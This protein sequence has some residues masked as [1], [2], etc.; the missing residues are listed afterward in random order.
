MQQPLIWLVEDEARHQLPALAILD[1]GLPDISG[2]S[3]AASCWRDKP[4]QLT[5]NKFLL[6]KKK[7]R[8]MRRFYVFCWIIPAN[9]RRNG[10]LHRG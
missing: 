10:N 9:H 7:R 2:L 4:L 6:L 3:C 5:F 1:V 8:E